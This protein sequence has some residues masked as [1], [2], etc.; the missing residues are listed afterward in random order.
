M[1]RTYQSNAAP[2][3]HWRFWDGQYVVYDAVTGDTHLLDPL[4]A[5]LVRRLIA[6]PA[7]LD[8]LVTDCG[9]EVVEPAA[10]QVKRALDQL[11]AAGLV[12]SNTG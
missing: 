6:G 10:L 11:S 1:P 12:D 5:A 4:H 9:Q 8:A 7:D 2:S 3:L